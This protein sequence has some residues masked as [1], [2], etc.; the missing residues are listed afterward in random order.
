[1]E[2][3]HRAPIRPS[4]QL[5][6][7]PN[8]FLSR[9]GTPPAA[10]S[11]SPRVR[12]SSFLATQSS[13]S[14][15]ALCTVRSCQRSNPS[16]SCKLEPAINSPASPPSPPFLFSPEAPPKSTEFVAERP[17]TCKLPRMNSTSLVNPSF[18]PLSYLLPYDT[19]LLPNLFPLSNLQQIEKNINGRC[20]LPPYAAPA[21]PYPS[22]WKQSTPWITRTS[23]PHL[24]G[25]CC[26]LAVVRRS[27]EV[28]RRPPPSHPRR[29]LLT[30]DLTLGEILFLFF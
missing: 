13:P 17:Q 7:Q 1:M 21:D 11:P 12:S 14:T 19:A 29:R 10:D 28:R 25:S 16:P 27:S 24:A 23:S 22:F 20:S 30:G 18:L 9:T 4:R 15:A 2:A 5:S 26:A 6:P 8:S 3:G